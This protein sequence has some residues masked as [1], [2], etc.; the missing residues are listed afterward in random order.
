MDTPKNKAV[1]AVKK[2]AKKVGLNNATAVIK[3][4]AANKV[5]YRKEHLG[6]NEE[7]YKTFGSPFKKGGSVKTKMQ[8][9]GAKKERNVDGPPATARPLE[10]KELLKKKFKPKGIA[11]KVGVG[12]MSK[13]YKLKNN[14][15]KGGSVKKK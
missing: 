14:L 12:I 2:A 6:L 3:K 4:E 8:K 1:K 7:D 9:G 13:A 11:S 15:K 10:Y 5:K